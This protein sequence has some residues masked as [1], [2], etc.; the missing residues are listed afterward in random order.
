M[1][2]GEMPLLATSIPGDPQ[3]SFNTLQLA[4]VVAIHEGLFLTLELQSHNSESIT[5]ANNLALA[6]HQ[7]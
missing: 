4:A 3:D 6:C 7:V 1:G 5:G 2:V